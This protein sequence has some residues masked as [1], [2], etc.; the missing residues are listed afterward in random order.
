MFK[1]A[2]DKSRIPSRRKKKQIFFPLDFQGVEL[3]CDQENSTGVTR[4]PRMRS[5]RNL[6]LDSRSDDEYPSNQSFTPPSPA[7]GSYS[8]AFNIPSPAGKTTL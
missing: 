5:P 4:T 1:A 8:F 7:I 2:A 6:R 3:R